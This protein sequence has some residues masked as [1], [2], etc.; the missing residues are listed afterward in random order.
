MV[1]IKQRSNSPDHLA[2]RDAF[3]ARCNRN[4]NRGVGSV[5]SCLLVPPVTVPGLDKLQPVPDDPQVIIHEIHTPDRLWLGAHPTPNQQFTFTDD[6]KK[7]QTIAIG[8][9]NKREEKGLF[10]FTWSDE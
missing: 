4:G 7:S 10:F 1:G 3:V 6:E 8:V 9:T 2:R 5:S